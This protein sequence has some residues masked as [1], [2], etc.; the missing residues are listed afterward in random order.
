MHLQPHK[1]KMKDIDTSTLEQLLVETKGENYSSDNIKRLERNVPEQAFDGAL[2]VKSYDQ[3]L[4]ERYGE[5]NW[6]RYRSEDTE[7]DHWDI[8]AYIEPTDVAVSSHEEPEESTYVD[9][10]VLWAKSDGTRT[11][12]LLRGGMYNDKKEK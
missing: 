6:A 9:D 5:G 4:D 2:G 3:V 11:L 8:I 1:T 10:Q 12:T 7:P